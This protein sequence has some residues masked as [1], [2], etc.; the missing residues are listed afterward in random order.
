MF[1]IRLSSRVR[2]AFLLTD[3]PL[4]CFRL[5]LPMLLP[6]KS[7]RDQPVAVAAEKGRATLL[8]QVRAILPFLHRVSLCLPFCG[9]NGLDGRDDQNVKKRL[10]YVKPFG[11]AVAPCWPDPVPLLFAVLFSSNRSLKVL[12]HTLG[13]FF[14][15]QMFQM[16]FSASRRINSRCCLGL[17][18][19]CWL[20]IVFGIISRGISLYPIV[21]FFRRA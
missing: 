10:K 18:V 16:F 5:L 1:G 11:W 2:L 3:V 19:E 17:H 14:S 9:L 13:L 8:A 6:G 20:C 7:L 15:F 4:L 21:T 12:V